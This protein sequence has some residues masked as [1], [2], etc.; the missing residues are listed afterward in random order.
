MCGVFHLEGGHF[1]R[2]SEETDLTQKKTMRVK[3]RDTRDA[4]P[5][6][7]LVVV[8]ES[9]VGKTSMIRQFVDHIFVAEFKA[10]IGADF[11]SRQL[12]VDDKMVTLQVWDT[13]GQERYRSL[14]TSY[15]KGCE[16][17]LIVFDVT[18][19][20]SFER[21]SSWCDEV[22]N[23]LGLSS[24]DGFPLFVVGNKTD[25]AAARKV[26]AKRAAEVSRAR[27]L[28]YVECSA[29]TGDN[30][31]AVFKAAAAS[32]LDKRAGMPPIAVMPM[33]VG[34][35]STASIPRESGCPC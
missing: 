10:T 16:A 23:N 31:E 21:V 11:S 29:K 5:I 7:K 26:T 20:G 32:A 12:P 34:N 3:D 4:N 18:D 33:S 22:R 1:D 2:K 35:L 17:A 25:D 13:A 9:G 30:I 24:T 15:F 8:G 6:I 28:S 14:S 19:E 27:G